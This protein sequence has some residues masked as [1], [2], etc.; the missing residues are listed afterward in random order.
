MKRLKET[1]GGTPRSPSRPPAQGLFGS[2]GFVCLLMAFL[3]KWSLSHL[4]LQ[5]HR[6]KLFKHQLSRTKQNRVMRGRWR[7][8]LL[9]CQG[10]RRCL[11]NLKP[12][13]TSGFLSCFILL[14]L[15]VSVF[16]GCFWEPACALKPLGSRCFGDGAFPGWGNRCHLQSQLRG[17]RVAK[18]TSIFHVY[19]VFNSLGNS[20]F[21]QN[22]FGG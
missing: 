12:S 14:C 13:V 3:S 16:V 11:G 2:R 21:K 17:T 22:H 5:G 10:D 15:R 1:E 6:I 8:L 20:A 4:D 9:R 18:P 19:Q 7:K